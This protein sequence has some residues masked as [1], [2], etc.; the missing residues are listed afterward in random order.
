MLRQSDT[1]HARSRSPPSPGPQSRQGILLAARVTIEA[2][3][4]VASN[5]ASMWTHPKGHQ[6]DERR[7]GGY[8]VEAPDGHVGRVAGSRPDPGHARLV[9][10]LDDRD[11]YEHRVVPAGA[12]D[13]IDHEQHVVHLKLTRKAILDAPL[14]DPSDL[15]DHAELRQHEDYYENFLHA[16]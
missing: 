7:V 9:V 2:D 14:G 5:V 8:S 11:G 12:V 16:P 6:A 13:A 15:Q 4:K 10:V 3:G 1:L